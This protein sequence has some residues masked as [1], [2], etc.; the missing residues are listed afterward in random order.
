MQREKRRKEEGR[1]IGEGASGSPPWLSAMATGEGRGDVVGT[2]R[3]KKKKKATAAAAVA[4]LRV[5][6][7][8]QGVLGG[9]VTGW[10]PLGDAYKGRKRVREKRY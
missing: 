10:T 2:R 4:C 5:P 8:E 1:K 3:G 7:L 9:G 6:A